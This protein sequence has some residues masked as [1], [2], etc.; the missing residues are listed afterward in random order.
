ME[1]GKHG[2]SGACAPQGAG[3]RWS[4]FSV[5]VFQ[6][7]AKASGKGCKKSAVKVRVKGSCAAPEK[8]NAKA[9]EIVSAL[10]AGTYTGKRNVSV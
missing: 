10:D 3:T 7:V 4:T 5:G 1:A 6:W 2:F 8:V 9:A